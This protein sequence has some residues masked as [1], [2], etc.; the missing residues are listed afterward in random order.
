MNNSRFERL[1]QRLSTLS[2][3]PCRIAKAVLKVMVERRLLIRRAWIE[4]CVQH[5]IASSV[6]ET[7]T[8]KQRDAGLSFLQTLQGQCGHDAESPEMGSERGPGGDAACRKQRKVACMRGHPTPWGVG[9]SGRVLHVASI[10]A[11]NYCI[12]GEH[13]RTDKGKKH[14]PSRM[15]RTS[16]GKQRMP[17]AETTNKTV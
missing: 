1:S 13:V 3:G 7:W 2:L 10:M 5:L 14:M 16:E 4:S 12:G 9:L 8:L 11:R 17:C 15:Y 6:S